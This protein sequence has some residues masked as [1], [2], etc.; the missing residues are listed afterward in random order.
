MSLGKKLIQAEIDR[1][2]RIAPDR[3]R[4]IEI[5][6]KRLK[7]DEV[8]KEKYLVKAAKYSIDCCES[9]ITKSEKTI[10]ELEKDLKKLK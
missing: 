8:K 4:T 9:D 2:K 1:L 10:A 5:Q 6:N 3:K 7:D